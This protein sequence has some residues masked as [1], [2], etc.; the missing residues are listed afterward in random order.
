MSLKDGM[1]LESDN[2]GKT[3]LYPGAVKRMQNY[4]D[5]P[6][7]RRLDWVNAGGLL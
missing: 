3:L 7:D 1:K 2:F 4:L 5:T 6:A